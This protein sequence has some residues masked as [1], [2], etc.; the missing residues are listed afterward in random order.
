MQRLCR[1]CQFLPTSPLC[2]DRPSHAQHTHRVL[3][4]PMGTFYPL[5]T[6]LTAHSPYTPPAFFPCPP[7]RMRPAMDS[8]GQMGPKGGPSKY[9][10]QLL[11]PIPVE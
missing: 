6:P 4:A 8:Q 5:P 2:Q 3:T 1:S 10:V 11:N 9:M 7:V